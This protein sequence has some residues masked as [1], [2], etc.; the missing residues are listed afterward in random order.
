MFSEFLKSGADGIKTARV[1]SAF[2]VTAVIEFHRVVHLTS[3][4]GHFQL[5]RL[6]EKEAEFVTWV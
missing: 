2:Y 3:R 1:N 4:D 6:R 5:P